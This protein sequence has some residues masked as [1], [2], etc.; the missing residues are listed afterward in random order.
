MVMS[1]ILIATQVNQ[2]MHRARNKL[3]DVKLCLIRSVESCKTIILLLKQLTNTQKL[4]MMLSFIINM[5]SFVSMMLSFIIN[6]LSL[7]CF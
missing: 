7:G 6:M 3:G 4:S 5:L 1:A 2:A